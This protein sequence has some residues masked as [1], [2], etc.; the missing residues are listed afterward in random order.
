MSIYKHWCRYCDSHLGYG[1]TA[2]GLCDKSECL[3]KE[4]AA[5]LTKTTSICSVSKDFVV[6]S[7]LDAGGTNTAFLERV[8]NYP[9]EHIPEKDLNDI[10]EG[11]RPKC[12]QPRAKV[13]DV[14]HIT[15]KSDGIRFEARDWN[16]EIGVDPAENTEDKLARGEF[17]VSVALSP[18]QIKCFTLDP[19]YAPNPTLQGWLE[20]MD[21]RTVKAVMDAT[22]KSFLEQSL[23]RAAD[24]ASKAYLDRVLG[25]VPK[26]I[27]D[28][29]DNSYCKAWD[30][31]VEKSNALHSPE[32]EIERIAL[33]VV[34][35]GQVW[36]QESLD[37]TQTLRVLTFHGVNVEVMYY[38]GVGCDGHRSF[39]T[40]D[41]LR[42]FW[43][44]VS[45]RVQR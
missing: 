28:S 26:A 4:R 13:F 7:H 14:H 36:E 43:T 10:Y 37:G 19:A 9:Y 38:P 3:S 25:D 45:P 39:I 34:R 40:E 17:T 21:K 35:E 8:R 33:P 11:R 20:E 27:R 30:R 41:A 32:M 29:I 15:V 6:K 16:Y 18:E 1:K 12:M 24:A 31:E 42:E 5:I 22:N 23:K 2:T 44:L